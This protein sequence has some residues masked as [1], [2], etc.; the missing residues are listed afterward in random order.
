VEWRFYAVARHR[1]VQLATFRSRRDP[2]L[3]L[4][5]TSRR[6]QV[7]IEIA[8]KVSRML[9]GNANFANHWNDIAGYAMFGKVR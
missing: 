6:L 9:T 2:E 8:H 3:A 7:L 4:S 5:R 1:G